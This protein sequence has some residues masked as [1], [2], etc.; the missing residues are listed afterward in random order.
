MMRLFTGKSNPI[1][2]IMEGIDGL[3]TSAGERLEI[4]AKLIEKVVDAQAKVIAAEAS[5]GGIA[6]WW[7]PLTML[8]FVGIIWWYVLSATFGW[9]PPDL[10]T[11]PSEMWLLIQ[12]GLGGYIG[13]RSGEKVVDKLLDYKKNKTQGEP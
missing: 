6:S 13:L 9:P 12:G 4:K 7:R 1:K 10:S 8:S 2:E 5:R 11:I 3:H